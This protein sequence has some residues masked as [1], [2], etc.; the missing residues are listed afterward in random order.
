MQFG[1][2]FAY[3]AAVFAQAGLVFGQFLQRNGQDH[4]VQ[5]PPA[6]MLFQHVK[7][8]QPFGGVNIGFALLLNI[9]SGGIDQNGVFGKEPVAISGAADPL[10]IIRQI[11][12]EMQTGL[13]QGGGFSG[14]GRTDD[15]I[16]RHFTQEFA[17][18]QF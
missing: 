18:A 12:R 13:A 11:N 6:T 4:P 16:P 14:A 3:L 9:T 10:Q 17:P 2:P 5:R 8:T 1:Q 7:K 15:H